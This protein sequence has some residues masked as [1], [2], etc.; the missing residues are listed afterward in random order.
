MAQFR[1]TC[2]HSLSTNTFPNTIEGVI[3]GDYECVYRSVLNCEECG[4]IWIHTDECMKPYMPEDGKI[5]QLF[6]ESTSKEYTEYFKNIFNMHFDDIQKINRFDRDTE[7]IKF[8]KN[9]IQCINEFKTAE[10][11]TSIDDRIR[12]LKSR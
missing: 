10:V 12:L 2:D 4:R 6:G 8:L 5:D 1:C 7:E 3:R 9:V 11:V